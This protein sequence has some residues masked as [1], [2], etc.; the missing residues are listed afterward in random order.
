M[1][2]LVWS[3][4]QTNGAVTLLSQPIGRAMIAAIASGLRRANCLGT[5]SPMTRLSK[6]GDDDHHAEADRL[7]GFR[8]KPEQC[9]PLRHGLA[10]AGARIGAG[11]D[12]D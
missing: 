12:A 3:S 7:G 9:Q 8:I 4:S 11:Q 6:G 5:S 2:A 1:S 10:Q